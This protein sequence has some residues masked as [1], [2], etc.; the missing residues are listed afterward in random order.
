MPQRYFV[1]QNF[2]N[3]F[4][5]PRRTSVPKKDI[6]YP[7]E[8][9]EAE[10]RVTGMPV[11]TVEW[12]HNSGSM[13]VSFLRQFASDQILIGN[14]RQQSSDFE[15]NSIMERS[16]SGIA[17]VVARLII[18]PHHVKPG[19]SRTFTCVGK[20]GANIVKASSKCFR[21]KHLTPID[22]NPNFFPFFSLSNGPFR[23]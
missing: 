23:S 8:P 4:F 5:I 7:A 20:S 16:P 12:V 21:R 6:Y 3:E 19:T 13:H 17:T 1:S 2:S 11:P 18:K 22:A 14:L 9:I 10:C 15:T